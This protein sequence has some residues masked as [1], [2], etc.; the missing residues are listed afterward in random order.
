MSATRVQVRRATPAGAEGWGAVE[1]QVDEPGIE[2]MRFHERHGFISRDP[3][4]GDHAL[5]W[6]RDL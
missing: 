1:I 4:T 6:W 2:A 3:Q 5:L